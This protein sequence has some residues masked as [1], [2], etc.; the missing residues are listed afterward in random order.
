[1]RW[2]STARAP[3]SRDSDGDGSGDF[4]E[5]W[6]GSDPN[7]SN[8]VALA[9]EGDFLVYASLDSPESLGGGMLE[10]DWAPVEGAVAGGLC[11]TADDAL[12]YGAIGD[13]GVGSLSAV[14][15]FEFDA[16]G[17]RRTLVSKGDG[18]A[19]VAEAGDLIWRVGGVGEITLPG[20]AVGGGWHQVALVIDRGVGIVRGF[21][22]GSEVGAFLLE[23]D[24]SISSAQGLGLGTGGGNGCASTTSPC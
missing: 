8:S 20:G 5:V 6:R 3:L 4:Y 19:I 13:P 11:F 16:P 7:S 14:L 9:R 23:D 2:S 12:D 22:D 1:M 24:T 15:W 10:M 17:A 21:Y 18:W